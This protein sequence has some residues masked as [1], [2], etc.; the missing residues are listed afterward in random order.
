MVYSSYVFC[1]FFLPTVLVVYF[2]LSTAKCYKVQRL[3]LVGASFFFYGYYNWNYL[4]IIIVSIVVNYA[5][6]VLLQRTRYKVL[7]ILGVLFNLFLLGYFKY[8]DFFIGNINH[9]FHTNLLMKNII[10][11]LG[12]SFFT[13]Q[14]ISFLISIRSG[15]E[16]IGRFIDYCTFVTFFPQLVAGP[17]VL[18]NEM[19]PQFKDISR[20]S[21]DINNFNRG[22][23]IFS[24]GLLKKTLVADTIALFVDNGYALKQVDFLSA[25][26]ISL[27]YTMQI[28]FDFS[29]YSDMAIGLGKMFNI[30]IPKNF[31]SPYKAKTISDFWRRWHITLGRALGTY[32]YK[33]L[34]G[35]RRGIA[36]TCVNLLITF[37]ISGFWHGASWTFIIWGGIYGVLMA[38]ER[39][40]NNIGFD[41]PSVIKKIYTFLAVNALWVLFRAETFN[42]ALKIFKGMISVSSFDILAVAKLAVD[43]I[44]FLPEIV[45]ALYCIVVICILLLIVFRGKDSMKLFDEFELNLKTSFITSLSIIISLVCMS[46]GTVFIYFN[47]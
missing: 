10:L 4:I 21:F 41:I 13:F 16:T 37:L 31:N 19:I 22:I 47:F 7:F 1:L 6:A 35:N 2:L 39:I 30:D 29:G 33:P 12:I 23:Y 18:Y 28:Y 27:S 44:V 32:I 40:I 42:D 5:I 24:I 46:R 45:S 9:I 38:T 14:Q 8:Y 43:D 17:I 15:E 34:G 11:P 20:R 26:I 25:W 3:F 36:R